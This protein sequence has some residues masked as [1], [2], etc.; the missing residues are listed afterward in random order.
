M[1]AES[2][3]IFLLCL[4]LVSTKSEKIAQTGPLSLATVIGTRRDRSAIGARRR[5]YSEDGKLSPLFSVN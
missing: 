4:Y 5:V 2:Q 3:G 1:A